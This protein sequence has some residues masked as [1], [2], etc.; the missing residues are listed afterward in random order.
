MTDHPCKGMTKPQIAAF[1]QIAAG[2]VS[3]YAAKRTISALLDRGLIV[4]GPDRPVGRDGLGAI[5][6]AQYA[7]PLTT[8]MDWCAW[9]S[10]NVED[11][12]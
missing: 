2:N 12:V 6:V 5:M 11:D 1:E 7:V 9:C 8:H 10:E 4:R 3:P